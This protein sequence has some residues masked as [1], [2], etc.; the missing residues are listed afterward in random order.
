MRIQCLVLLERGAPV[1]GSLE[2]P[3]GSTVPVKGVVVWTQPPDHP[4]FVPAEMGIEL[5]N[6]TEEYLRAVASLFAD[7]G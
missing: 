5:S 6:I 3:D 7:D 4:G 1:E 2:M